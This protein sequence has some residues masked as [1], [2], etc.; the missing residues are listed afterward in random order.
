MKQAKQC[1]KC[2][3]RRI[4]YVN[5]QPDAD[6]DFFRWRVIAQVRQPQG[7]DSPRPRLGELEAYVCTEC[8]YYESYVRSPESTPWEQLSGF[9]MVNPDVEPDGPYR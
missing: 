5:Y 2:N 1:P 4:G 6:G 8:G 7:Y 9:R 3:S